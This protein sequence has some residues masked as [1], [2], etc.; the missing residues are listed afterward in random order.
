MRLAVLLG[1]LSTTLKAAVM[2]EV[3]RHW[4]PLVPWLVEAS[5]PFQ[6][7]IGA[8]LRFWCLAQAE[9]F[10]EAFNLYVLSHG[11]AAR[12]G[13]TQTLTTGAV[14]GADIILEDLALMEDPQAY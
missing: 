2:T 5:Q 6:V 12:T 13:W 11:L 7:E 14:W 4:I 1:E 8:R 10:G 9:K 3:H